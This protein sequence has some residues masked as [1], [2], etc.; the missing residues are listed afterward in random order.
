MVLP[1]C[2]LALV[3]GLFFALLAFATTSFE[4]GLA[5]FIYPSRCIF[6]FSNFQY[7]IFRLFLG[8]FQ[9]TDKD[10]RLCLIALKSCILPLLGALSFP[11]LLLNALGLS[12][13]SKRLFSQK[14][15]D[16]A[17]HRISPADITH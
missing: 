3:I 7:C 9:E 2:F 16:H 5:P 10:I 11:L 8:G 4:I 1:S 6:A 17:F 12:L 15:Q 13:K 14:P